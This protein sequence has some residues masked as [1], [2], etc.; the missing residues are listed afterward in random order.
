MRRPHSWSVSASAGRLRSSGKRRNELGELIASRNRDT[1]ADAGPIPAAA[2]YRRELAVVGSR[3]ATPASM[4][5]AAALLPEL[6][7]PRPTVLPLERFAD[8]FELHRTG[9]ALKVVFT[10]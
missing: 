7:L 3:S 2:V 6:D 5:D 8:G 10:P 9:R 4:R 1:F